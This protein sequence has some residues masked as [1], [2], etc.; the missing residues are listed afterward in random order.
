MVAATYEVQVKY[1][2]AGAQGFVYHSNYYT[3]YDLVQYEFLYQN[4]YSFQDIIEAGVLFTIIDIHS[5]Y[6][7]PASFGDK[8]K[9]EMVVRSVTNVKTTVDYVVTRPADG[10]KIAVSRAIYACVDKNFR[11]LVFKR[12]LPG[13]YDALKKVCEPQS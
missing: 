8:L 5:K 6:Y 4:G 13:L 11:P 12:A 9:I 1:S 7:A 3:W 10:A 2:E